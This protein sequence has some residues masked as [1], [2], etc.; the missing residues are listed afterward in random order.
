MTDKTA[1]VDIPVVD[2]EL[3]GEWLHRAPGVSEMSAA[4]DVSEVAFARFGA[5]ATVDRMRSLDMPRA[6]ARGS[7]KKRENN[8]HP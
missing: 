2:L 4:T 3:P 6:A 1:V 7:V 5:P 8:G